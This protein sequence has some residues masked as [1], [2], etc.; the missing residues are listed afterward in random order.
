MTHKSCFIH[1][2]GYGNKHVTSRRAAGVGVGV[3][4]GGGGGGGGW[5]GGNMQVKLTYIAG[6]SLSGSC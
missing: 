6:R 3:G 5:G 1:R 4:C 2:V